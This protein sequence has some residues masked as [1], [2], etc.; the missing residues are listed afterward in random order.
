MEAFEVL[1]TE[2][3]QREQRLRAFVQESR[4]LR[5][6][7]VHL[8]AVTMDGVHFTGVWTEG[9]SIRIEGVAADYTVL[10]A[11]MGAL[12]NDPFFPVPLTLTK[13]G[14]ERDAPHLAHSAG[15]I[16]FALHGDW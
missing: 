1:H 3:V 12:E 8:G 13:A 15:Q 6:L 16:R 5:P 2:V 9:R 14:E 4:P 10:A 7:L 11:L